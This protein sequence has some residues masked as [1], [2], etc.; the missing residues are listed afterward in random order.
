MCLEGQG[1]GEGLPVPT[2]LALGHSTFIR[3]IPRSRCTRPRSEHMSSRK[4]GVRTVCRQPQQQEERKQCEIQKMVKTTRE[5]QRCT[6][7]LLVLRLT[8]VTSFDA[9]FIV[10]RLTRFWTATLF[11]PIFHLDRTQDSPFVPVPIDRILDRLPASLY[12]PID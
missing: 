9:T 2:D 3:L 5:R 6:R 8:K 7:G 4:E 1:E 11:E 10:A 12:E